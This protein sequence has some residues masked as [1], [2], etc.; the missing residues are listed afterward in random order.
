MFKMFLSEY[1][2]ITMIT[3]GSNYYEAVAIFLRLSVPPWRWQA[4]P[5]SYQKV[6]VVIHCIY[7]LFINMKHMG[8]SNKTIEFTV[9]LLLF[10]STKKYPRVYGIFT[11]GQILH[12]HLASYYIWDLVCFHTSGI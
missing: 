7:W 12:M 1:E 9:F 6:K 10:A 4:T 8:S 11:N 2:P 3:Y 5:L